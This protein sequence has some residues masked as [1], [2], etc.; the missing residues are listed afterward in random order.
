MAEPFVIG[1]TG[2]IGMG[3]SETAKLFA[4]EGIPVHDADAAI[5]RLYG[6]GGAAV[7]QIARE[8][9]GAVQDGAVDRALLSALVTKDKGALK[10]LEALVH[11]LVA[12]DRDAFL[13]TINA[14]IV[15]FDVPLL[16][17]TGA[18]AEADAIVVVSAPEEV[19]RARVLA[20]PGMTAEKFESLKAR[21][22]GDAQK[23]QQ[24]HYVVITDKGLDHAREQVK[25]I[26]ADVRNKLAHA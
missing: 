25:M 10:K 14:P 5:A 3:K 1:L 11:P 8:F 7:A 21:Q 12:A 13:Q 17:E 18:D 6:K 4:A 2:S 9:P 20:R 26:L 16:F 24:A 22:L 23:R 15:L 19:Q